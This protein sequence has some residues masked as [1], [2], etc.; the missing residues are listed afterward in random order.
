MQQLSS[1]LKMRQS[2]RRL[3]GGFRGSGNYVIC[4]YPC[5]RCKGM[6]SQ[7][8]RHDLTLP[9]L[10]INMSSPCLRDDPRLCTVLAQS[11][12]QNTLCRKSGTP[13]A[14]RCQRSTQH[15]IYLG[16]EA[17]MW[18]F[19]R[20]S[21]PTTHWDSSAA[22]RRKVCCSDSLQKKGTRLHDPIKTASK[23]KH[24]PRS[25]DLLTPGHSELQFNQNQGK[26]RSSKQKKEASTQH[27]TLAWRVFA[28]G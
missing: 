19:L 6:C 20:R 4:F 15:I 25:T 26:E 14:H 5:P 22:A 16:R 8:G 1:A 23:E 28:V 17:S 12:N 24:F 3:P 21:S 27:L 11:P 13:A 7:S 2:F 10:Q 18:A 9:F